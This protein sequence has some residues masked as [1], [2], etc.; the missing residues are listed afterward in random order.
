MTSMRSLVQRLSQIAEQ[1]SGCINWHDHAHNNPSLGAVVANPFEVIEADNP[2]EMLCDFDAHNRDE[3]SR[4]R[5]MFGRAR[6]VGG[7]MHGHHISLSSE[8]AS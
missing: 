1:H 4:D 2:N 7:V 5:L 3:S 6:L 8:L